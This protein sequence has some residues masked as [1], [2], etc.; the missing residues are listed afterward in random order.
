V[1]SS[2]TSDDRTLAALRELYDSRARAELDGADLLCP[3]SDAV[4]SR[5]ALVATI[6]VVK[7][8]P[9]PAEASG[10]AALSGP[11]GDAV[12]RALEALGWTDHDVFYALSRPEPG[13]DPACC[14]SRIRRVIEATDPRVVV[15][16]DRVA[17]QDL[18]VAFDISLPVSGVPVVSRGRSIVAL[19]DFE[20]ALGDEMLKRQAWEQLKAA[21]PAGPA[22]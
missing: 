11:D 10:G 21:R 16:L 7:G 20:A 17:A 13:S 4:A 19:D 15:A 12:L 18:E 5:G 2:T 1:T 22:Y 6:A 3:G 14:A 9:G 8:L